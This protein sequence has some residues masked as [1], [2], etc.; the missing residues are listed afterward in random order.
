MSV[1]WCVSPAVVWSVCLSGVWLCLTLW[2]SRLALR[3][4]GVRSSLSCARCCSCPS[5]GIWAA[6]RT[7][8]GRSE[9]NALSPAGASV[10]TSWSRCVIGWGR[11]QSLTA[12]FQLCKSVCVLIRRSWRLCL[13]C[14][15][16]LK[17]LWS[18]MM[19]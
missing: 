12:C 19:N 13:R 14:C 6:S 11:C 7:R 17:T 9:R 3:S 16:S 15:S 1:D 4:R 10:T 5:P 8:C 2:R 18:S